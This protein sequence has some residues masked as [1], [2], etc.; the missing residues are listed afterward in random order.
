[1]LGNIDL[2][3]EKLPGKKKFRRAEILSIGIESISF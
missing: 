3:L 2:R 1:M